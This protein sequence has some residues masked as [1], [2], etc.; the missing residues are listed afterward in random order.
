MIK[1][2]IYI[3]L[4]FLFLGLGIVGIILPILPTVPFFL[5]TSFFF[6]KG[7]TRFNNWFKNTKIYHRYLDNFVQNKVMTLKGEILL[8]SFVSSII[9]IT[10]WHIDNLFASIGLTT[11]IIIKYL[12]F[13]TNIKTVTK[14]QY[15]ELR[16][17]QTC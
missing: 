8:L 7:S 11:L 5:L 15:F 6:S 14:K 4:G 13:I 2:S 1:K 12:Y 17:K 16:G 3:T 9:F 10:M